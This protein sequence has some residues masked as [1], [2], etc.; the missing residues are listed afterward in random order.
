LITVVMWIG[1][2]LLVTVGVLG[3]ASL[4]ISGQITRK[5]RDDGMW[6]EDDQ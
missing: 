4:S 3:F 1:F 2:G 5:E 6:Q